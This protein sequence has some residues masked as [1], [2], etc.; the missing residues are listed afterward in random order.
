[1]D[2]NFDPDRLSTG[3]LS[4]AVIAVHLVAYENIKNK[5]DEDGNAPT[6]HWCTFFETADHQSVR[7]D[8]APGYGSD[9][10]RGKV[11]VSSKRYDCTKNHV[12]KI[13][14]PASLG[15]TAQKIID[16]VVRNGRQK[17]QF[18]PEWEG[19]RYWNYVLISDLEAAGYIAQGNAR[20]ALAVLSFYWKFPPGSGSEARRVQQGTFRQ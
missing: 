2:S 4:K 20:A 16:L 12:K 17:Y 6:N 1:M 11:E 5:G 19:C 3:D 8:M 14:I 10:L 7:L 9:G 18:T 13:T 15:L